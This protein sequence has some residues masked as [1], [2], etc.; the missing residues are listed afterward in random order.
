MCTY[1]IVKK[2]FVLS[3]MALSLGAGAYA[4]GASSCDD[5]L[6]SSLQECQRIVG[7]LRADKA[8]QMRVFASDGSEFTAGE[9]QWMKNQLKLIV[10]LCA[11]GN[12]GD[13][14]RR[15]ADVQELLREHHRSYS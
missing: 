13:A 1:R 5:K 12:P 2:L 15:L 14:E 10:K 4:A 7:S 11:D 3:S 8:G 9:A 6:T